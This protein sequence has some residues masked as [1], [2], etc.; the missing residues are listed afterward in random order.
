MTD[1]DTYRLYLALGSLIRSLRRSAPRTE[2]AHASLSAL[3]AL[4]AKG[5]MRIGELPEHEGISGPSMTRVVSALTTHGYLRRTL[6]PTDGRAS[7]IE[8]T[9]RGHAHVTDSRESRLLELDRRVSTLNAED[10][11]AL[12]RAVPVLENLVSHS[13]F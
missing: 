8:L 1:G 6:D 9:E 7:L 2:L 10:R 4:A 13:D 3:A 11:A 12:M 5:P